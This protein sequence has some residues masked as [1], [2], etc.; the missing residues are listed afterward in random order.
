MDNLGISQIGA[1]RRRRHDD[2]GREHRAEMLMATTV[3][4]VIQDSC[5]KAVKPP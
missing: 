4:R 5:T 3:C 2:K 1:G